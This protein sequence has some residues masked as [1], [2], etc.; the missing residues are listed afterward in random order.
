MTYGKN[1]L[2]DKELKKYLSDWN[3]PGGFDE[4]KYRN[5]KV[6]N[7][8][9]IPSGL[10]KYN[11]KKYYPNIKSIGDIGL[12]LISNK[13]EESKI[14]HGIICRIEEY[15]PLTVYDYY[16]DILKY[17]IQNVNNKRIKIPINQINENSHVYIDHKGS[18]DIL[19]GTT[20]NHT[21]KPSNQFDNWLN[22]I[23]KN[24]IAIFKQDLKE[25]FNE[26]M[27]ESIESLSIN[28]VTTSLC[29]KGWDT[30]FNLSPVNPKIKPFSSIGIHPNQK[31]LVEMYF[32]IGSD[33]KLVF[34]YAEQPDKD[35]IGK[36][37]P[38]RNAC[39]YNKFPTFCESI[40]TA[41]KINQMTQ[42][43]D[44]VKDLNNKID[45]NQNSNQNQVN[46]ENFIIKKKLDE[47]ISKYPD[48][49]KIYDKSFRFGKEVIANFN[50]IHDKL[51]N[52]DSKLNK[53]DNIDSKLNKL[54]NI[55]SKLDESINNDLNQSI[56]ST[57]QGV[58]IEKIYNKVRK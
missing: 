21:T 25:I 23:I 26:Q 39:E 4:N 45:E 46:N 27:R 53:L 35:L 13:S 42:I 20:R 1:G 10:V 50:Q 12:N 49:L 54:D 9:L 17:P 14:I 6:L 41:T 31:K 56:K 24:I 22:S 44:I 33:N 8:F 43:Y 15:L 19:F 55:D 11:K 18:I 2:S 28:K 37:V 36:M 58:M 57:G 16:R 51:D 34:R 32:Y 30:K 38:S 40:P 48:L 52:I 29:S 3:I 5:Y 7:R 47:I